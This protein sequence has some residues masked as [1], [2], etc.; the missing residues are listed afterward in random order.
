MLRVRRVHLKDCD[1][2]SVEL[3]EFSTELYECEFDKISNLLMVMAN[4]LAVDH[5]N[6]DVR[7]GGLTAESEHE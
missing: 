4:E 2:P 1:Q 5:Y 6:F 3:D 7:C